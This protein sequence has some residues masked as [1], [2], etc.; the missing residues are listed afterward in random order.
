MVYMAGFLRVTRL[1][2]ADTAWQGCQPASQPASQ[3]TSQPASQQA[4]QPASGQ[5]G[6]QV[7][8]DTAGTARLARPLQLTLLTRHGLHGTLHDMASTAQKHR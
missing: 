5:P 2:T 3:T 4:S 7:E 6:S 8:A 1:G